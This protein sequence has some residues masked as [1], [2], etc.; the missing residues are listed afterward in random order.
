M[1]KYYTL[2]NRI[3]LLIN[4]KWFINNFTKPL[5]FDLPKTKFSIAVVNISDRTYL[6]LTR[7]TKIFLTSIQRTLLNLSCYVSG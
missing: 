3:R 7:S 2:W 1:A 4:E 6:F 5:L